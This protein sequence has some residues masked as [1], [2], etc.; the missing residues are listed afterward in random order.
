[1]F[2][3]KINFT[4]LVFI[5]LSLNFSQQALALLGDQELLPPEQAFKVSGKA[6]NDQLIITWD[7]ADG[8]YLYRD[9]FKIT[10]QDASISLT[11]PVFPAG[12]I[13]HD[14]NFGE[15][16]TYRHQVSAK[17]PL[18]T[19]PSEKLNL[20]IQHQGC[21]DIG[22]CYPPQKLE[23]L[24]TLPEKAMTGD[25]LNPLQVLSN[26]IANP[27][28]NLFA[29][30]LLPPDQAFQ[31]QLTVSNANTLYVHWQI[32]KGYYLYRDKMA[33]SVVDNSSTQ[34]GSYTIP[35]GIAKTE[36]KFGEVEIFYDSLGFDVPLS[37]IETKAQRIQV[38]VKYQGCADQ[39]VCYP[40]MQK[41]I[42]LN[43]PASNTNSPTLVAKK[44]PLSSH[45]S[46]QNLIAD[47]LAKDGFWLTLA[48]FFGFGL[49]L[50]F[51]P[52]IFPMIPILSGIIVG[53][54][55]Y[56]ST[57][58]GFLLSLSYVLAAAVAYTVFGVLAALFGNNL[59]A[60]LQQPWIII[61]FSS[62]FILLALSMFGFYNLEL[63]KVLQA[64]VAD[65]S[66]KHRN[67]GMLG[68]ALMGAF[69]ALIVGPCVAAPLAGVL[70]YIGQTGDA[71]LGGSALFVMGLGMGA[72]LLA[73]GASAGSILP[74]AG[75]WMNAIKAV[76]GLLML[77]VAVWMLERI[78][79]ASVSLFLW[80]LLLIIPAIFL[81][82][83]DALPAGSSGWQKLWKGLGVI[84]LIYGALLLIG[85]AAGNKNPLQPLQGLTLGGNQNHQ[86]LAF[87]RIKSVQELDQYINQASAQNKWVM[88]DYYADWCISCKEMEVYTFTDPQV[89]KALANFVVLQADV[90]QMNDDDKALL[91]RF[92]LIGP[93]AILFFD[94]N[95]QERIVMR[96][97]GYLD[98][99]QF[100]SHLQQAQ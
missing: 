58:R 65:I 91:E 61:L 10:A 45:I 67:N 46:A 60:D 43:L 98:A 16:E 36:E 21:A 15:V 68:A 19:I 14:A 96:V 31:L 85:L 35:K 48:G 9:K 42:N 59:Q 77:A 51:T 50:A 12:K 82:A 39:G 28:L 92:D 86:E 54:G 97:V 53:Q 49:L 22:I 33:L 100:I 99:E 75:R 71:I 62:I 27:A 17:L 84:M 8:Y 25:A 78:L 2:S 30:K 40:P 32:A 29:D 26:S 7:I 20:I 18:P 4:K 88:L 83:L 24:V 73:L 72:P 89:Q 44:L 23:L 70:I 56:V 41:T 11:E 64:K 76:F 95:Q 13:K 6:D 57:L 63:P 93:P 94:T 66:D 47:N 87:T 37:R 38:V 55:G 90:T 1:M 52:C 34:L 69:S 81:G 79:P 80:V 74:K 3:V 5:L